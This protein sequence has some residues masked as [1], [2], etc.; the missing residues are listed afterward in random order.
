VVFAWQNMAAAALELPEVRVDLLAMESGIA[1]FDLTLTMQELAEDVGGVLEYRRDLFEPGTI[2]RLVEHLCMQLERM[3]ATPEQPLATLPLLTPAEQEQ[4]LLDWNETRTPYLHDQGLAALF[5]AQVKQ[6][7]EAIALVFEEQQVSYGELDRRANHL[8]QYLHQW[9]VRTET[10]V[11]LCLERS[12]AM[13]IAILGIL[14]AG[15]AYLPLDPA[16]PPERLAFVLHDA[17]ASVLLS[18]QSL[19]QGLPAVSIPLLCLD[20]DWPTIASTPPAPAPLWQHPDHLAYVIYTSGSTGTPKGVLVP[21]RQVTRLFA[22][23]QTQFRFGPQD[24]WTLFHSIAFDFSVWELWGA[25]LFGGR[26]TVVPWWQSREPESFFH[27]LQEQQISVLNLTPSA[28]HQL[29]VAASSL[30]EGKS[31]LAL[32]LVIFG[33]EALDLASVRAWMTLVGEHSPHLVNMYGI[34]ETTVHVTWQPLSLPVIN[35]GLKSPI[36]RPLPDLQVYVLD[37]GGQPVP[38]GVVGE[39]YVGGAGVT[40][41]YLGR[42]DLTAQRFVPHPWSRQPGARLYRSGDLARYTREGQLEYLGRNDAQVKLRGFRIELGEIEAALQEHPSVR[43]AVVVVQER[44]QGEKQLVAYIVPASAQTPS[45]SALRTFLSVRLP[46][47]MLPAAFVPLEGLPLTANGKLDRRA[48]PDPDS[49]R[50]ELGKEYMAPQNEIERTLAQIWSQILRIQQVG[51]H[52]NFFELGGDSILSI[53]IVAKAHAA[54]LSLTPRHLFQHQT[55]AQLAAVVGSIVLTQAEPEVVEGAMP[56]MPIHH[57]FFARQLAQPQHWNQAVLLQ[58]RQPLDP[59]LLAQAL[60][61]VLKQHDGLRLRAHQQS[62][63][64]QLSFATADAPLPFVRVDLSGLPAAQQQAS[65]QAAATALQASL[66]L[67][68]GPLLRVALFDLGAGEPA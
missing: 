9:G 13:V 51:V 58:A 10:L 33:G 62:A 60:Q 57:W 38:V 32:R 48:L 17:R 42:P 22:S 43:E 44:Q 35:G 63:G 67:M 49:G 45:L 16:S 36:G 64:W 40:R 53:Q 54:G 2:E 46:A 29:V 39:L 50:P 59:A 14:K 47:H 61:A 4:V 28:F 66:N 20:R 26:L 34:T 30:I 37:G 18:E 7:P 5:E 11:G 25:L 12:M 23:T 21:H 52:D 41:G 31:L 1:R 19:L 27:L 24:H 55:I 65:L 3:V 68:E 8:A 6:A 15:G 56:L